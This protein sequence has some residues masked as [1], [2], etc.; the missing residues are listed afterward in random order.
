MPG[1]VCPRP[2]PAPGPSD[3]CVEIRRRK[4]RLT[5]GIEDFPSSV[6]V[7]RDRHPLQGCD[8][9]GCWAG[10]TGT[11]RW[12]CWWCCRTAARR[13]C[14][15]FSPM[16]SQACGRG[17]RD[18]GV[19]RGPGATG[20]GGGVVDATGG[21]GRRRR[22]TLR[23]FRSRRTPVHPM[24]QLAF[25]LDDVAPE[26]PPRVIGRPPDGSAGPGSGGRG[27]QVGVPDRQVPRRGGVGR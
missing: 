24:S 11:V 22:R 17:G 13:C 12:S 19:D 23:G 20:G 16:P 4:P 9:C 27:G 3:R 18:G 8:R 6:T 26:P 2:V 10:C 15:R 14:R 1:P 7:T 21:R 5:T 25:D